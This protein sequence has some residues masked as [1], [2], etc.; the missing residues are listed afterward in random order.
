MFTLRY[1]FVAV[2]LCFGAS[3]AAVN[4]RSLS[5]SN[6]L[7][8]VASAYGSPYSVEGTMLDTC[9]CNSTACKYVNA[10]QSGSL[11]T[12][13]TAYYDGSD[14]TGLAFST[15]SETLPD[16]I[17]NANNPCNAGGTVD[18][19]ETVSIVPATSYLNYGG[20]ANFY[21]SNMADCNSGVYASFTL[22]AFFTCG[23]DSYQTTCAGAN[24]TMGAASSNS[25]Y[26]TIYETS[27]C[28]TS[29]L[30]ETVGLSA[31]CIP[32]V[33]SND[34]DDDNTNPFY[35]YKTPMVVGYSSSSSGDDD[36]VQV[37][38]GA[39]T[40]LIIAVFLFFG[41]GVGLTWVYF[42]HFAASSASK[43]R[44]NKGGIDSAT[45]NAV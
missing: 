35:I 43:E 44:L 11:V 27:A 3:A 5:S 33:A 36:T 14:C 32:V 2:A 13:G 30:T 45:N 34:D 10:T 9:L 15:E 18:I 40:F 31:T 26:E 42:T 1:L 19:T 28:D 12:V 7:V 41:L 22:A 37:N 8:I 24:V 38:K 16:T 25:Y 21:Y 17:N 39:Y 20:I 29:Y 4:H 6:A 23:V